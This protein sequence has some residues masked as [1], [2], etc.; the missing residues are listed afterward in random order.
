MNHRVETSDTTLRQAVSLLVAAFF[1]LLVLCASFGDTSD[2]FSKPVTTAQVSGRHSRA[3]R[4]R[5]RKK[6]RNKERLRRFRKYRRTGR[7]E[8]I[9]ALAKERRARFDAGV[10]VAEEKKTAQEAEKRKRDSSVVKVSASLDPH[11]DAVADALALAKEK[12]APNKGKVQAGTPATD[13]QPSAT[14]GSGFFEQDTVLGGSLGTV[15]QAQ[16]QARERAQKAF[17]AGVAAQRE[18][19][20]PAINQ[21]EFDLDERA[22]GSLQREVQARADADKA[23]YQRELKEYGQQQQDYRQK[24]QEFEES[25]ERTLEHYEEHGFGGTIQPDRSSPEVVA[26]NSEP[27]HVE[28][29]SGPVPEDALMDTG[30]PIAQMSPDELH[31][32]Q[33]TA[34]EAQV[35][36][37]KA[38]FSEAAGDVIGFYRKYG[39]PDTP[40]MGLADAAPRTGLSP[41]GMQT[42]G[43]ALSADARDTAGTA[44]GDESLLTER[45]SQDKLEPDRIG[46]TPAGDEEYLLTESGPVGAQII[47][48]GDVI[49]EE[50]YKSLDWKREPGTLITRRPDGLYVARQASQLDIDFIDFAVRSQEEAERRLGRTPSHQEAVDAW[51]DMVKAA[52]FFDSPST[53]DTGR[54]PDPDAPS[55]RVEYLRQEYDGATELS[56]AMAAGDAVRIQELQEQYGERRPVESDFQR[57]V[58]QAL[59]KNY[60]QHLREYRSHAELLGNVYDDAIAGLAADDEMLSMTGGASLRDAGSFGWGLSRVGAYRPIVNAKGEIVGMRLDHDA[61]RPGDGSGLN[62]TPVPIVKTRSDF[63]EDA[64]GTESEYLDRSFLEKAPAPGLI[65]EADVHLQDF[66]GNPNVQGYAAARGLEIGADLLVPYYDAISNADRDSGLVTAGKVAFDT[67]TTVPVVGWYTRGLRA[68]K[69]GQGSQLFGRTVRDTFDPFYGAS[70]L[71]EYV[72]PRKQ[73]ASGRLDTALQRAG[74]EMTY[75][76]S[77]VAKGGVP[78]SYVA[79][80]SDTV[81]L[82]FHSVAGVDQY[83]QTLSNAQ[84]EQAAQAA[85]R[86]RNVL[87]EMSGDFGFDK[88]LA[89]I[90]GGR[91]VELR[92]PPITSH[93]GGADTHATPNLSHFVSPYADRPGYAPGKAPFE[94]QN[95]N[96]PQYGWFVG[97]PGQEK[98]G[99]RSAFGQVGPPGSGGFAHVLGGPEGS[100]TLFDVA[101]EV[102]R[103]LDH[104]KRYAGTAEIE[105]TVPVGTEIEGKGIIYDVRVG[106]AP[107]HYLHEGQ[108]IYDKGANPDWG[109]GVIMNADTDV[110][111]RATRGEVTQMQ[112]QGLK[113]LIPRYDLDWRQATPNDIERLKVQAALTNDPQ[114]KEFLEQAARDLA[115]PE[116]WRARELARV[117]QELEGLP[118]EAATAAAA[119]GGSEELQRVLRGGTPD[120]ANAEPWEIEGFNQSLS[121][122]QR[123]LD[124]IAE[125]DGRIDADDIADLQSD[126]FVLEETTSSPATERLSKIVADATKQAEAGQRRLELLEEARKL[127]T[128]DEWR[129]RNTPGID[130]SE[131]LLDDGRTFSNPAA[132]APFISGTLRRT[133]H[134]ATAAAQS[135]AGFVEYDPSLEVP[136]PTFPNRRMDSDGESRYGGDQEYDPLRLGTQTV[137]SAPRW[138]S[139]PSAPRTPTTPDNQPRTPVPP[140]EQPP[141]TP[142]PPSEMPPRTPAPPPEPPPRTPAPPSEKPPRTPAPPTDKPPRTPAPPPDKPPRTPAPPPEK[143]PRTPAPPPEKPPRTPAPPPE[144]PPRTPAPPPEPPPRTPAPPS[145]TP[146]RTPAPPSDTPPRTPA[147]PPNRPPPEPPRTPGSIPTLTPPM[148]PPPPPPDPPEQKQP[149]RPQQRKRGSDEVQRIIQPQTYPH[150]VA[151]NK[152]GFEWRLNLHTGQRSMLPDRPSAKPPHKTLRVVQYS[153]NMPPD[154]TLDFGAIDAVVGKDGIRLVDD[155]P[156]ALMRPRGRLASHRL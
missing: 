47:R 148:K 16:G 94:A 65:G 126:L 130:E 69:P 118:D 84:Y 60:G 139:T 15:E 155:T 31:Q 8:P 95:V 114:A 22:G 64:I 125:K 100:G 54:N 72:S 154:R 109:R 50:Q 5:A 18:Y 17:E 131:Y 89:P 58:R 120:L 80:S 37:N 113:G 6:R 152:D 71:T 82:P 149:L 106:D 10:K 26:S 108:L 77:L 87:T 46:V 28:R 145:D 101:Q 115:N 33:T 45:P 112:L 129:I 44:A 91:V 81:R 103:T 56:R 61:P 76:I 1:A 9:S 66:L 136:S 151:W 68:M 140:P 110:Q 99:A 124:R 30:S 34:S 93:L 62:N 3:S 23:R 111:R 121:S 78:V 90:P 11:A 25:V 86:A 150:T 40:G 55:R 137:P 116:E 49:S 74:D 57:V 143:P 36:Q 2:V 104:P 43:A 83:K 70:N 73:G 12:V 88:P 20:G 42:Y 13:A 156:A 75:P 96:E 19:A 146:P 85:V 7:R 98:F 32:A 134:G 4:E 117:Q 144:K 147:P 92:N 102:P 97:T 39:L 138:P 119:K 141:R 67:A 24:Q 132:H 135:D 21:G 79:S 48:P 38:R 52:G 29:Y 35:A 133:G 27:T 59:E 107:G 128:P 14:P 53:P 105:R 127:E 123:K 142:A 153:D 41:A 63:I 51:A 122:V